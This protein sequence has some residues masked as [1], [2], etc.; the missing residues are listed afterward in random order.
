M[1]TLPQD[2]LALVLTHVPKA[3]PTPLASTAEWLATELAAGPS[4][5]SLFSL[6]EAPS[7]DN[8]QWS[9]HR[10]PGTGELE[11]V[12]THFRLWCSSLTCNLSIGFKLSTR[13]RVDEPQPDNNITKRSWFT[14]GHPIQAP[15]SHRDRVRETAAHRARRFYLVNKDVKNVDRSPALLPP[16]LSAPRAFAP[17]SPWLGPG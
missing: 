2:V 4:N 1:D 11:T 8:C 15:A 5:R 17:R 3:R 12:P 16:A 13:L 6:T 10:T 9:A 7:R 14:S